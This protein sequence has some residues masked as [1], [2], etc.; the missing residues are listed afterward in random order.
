MRDAESKPAISLKLL[1]CL[2]VSKKTQEM[3]QFN[4]WWL[5]SKNPYCGSCRIKVITAYLCLAESCT[6]IATIAVMAVQE[7]R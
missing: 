7:C 2:S 4:T 6:A 5:N 1:S 3:G